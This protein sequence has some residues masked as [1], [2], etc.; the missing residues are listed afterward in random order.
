MRNVMGLFGQ[1]SGLLV[2]LTLA[3]VSTDAAAQ[4]ASEP[5]NQPTV[6]SAHEGTTAAPLVPQLMRYTGTAPNRAGDVVEAT[7][8]VF[9]SQLGGEAL[10]QETQRVQVGS[11]GKFNALLGA[12]TEGGLPQTLF[13]AGQGQWLAVSIERAE[14]QPR[15]KLASVAYAMKAADAETLGGVPAASFVTQSQLAAAAASL[16]AQA[17]RKILPETTPAGSGTANYLAYWTGSAALGDSAIYQGGTATAPLLGIGTATP[18][19]TL[20]V[21]GA[22]IVRGTLIMVPDG[23]ATATA[24]SASP[25][26]A[27]G[28]S[29]FD[30]T[31]N[32]PQTNSFGW[33]VVGLG[34]N[35]PNPYAKLNLMYVAGSAAAKSTGFAIGSTGLVGFAPGQTFPGTVSAI[36]A[37]TGLTANNSGGVV[38]LGI[39]SAQV[40]TLGATFNNFTGVGT[41]S[42]NPGIFG[43]LNATNS[44][45]SSGDGIFASGW[46][47]IGVLGTQTGVNATTTGSNS[48]GVS[49]N[50]TGA[51]STGIKGNGSS[52]GGYFTNSSTNS[53]A[54][55]AQNGSSGPALQ[56]SNSAYGTAAFVTGVGPSAVSHSQLS[57]FNSALW[58]D[59]SA[60]TAIIGSSDGYSGGSFFSNGNGYST[61]TAQNFALN[62][63][64]LT[65][66]APNIGIVGKATGTTPNPTGVLG[67]GVWGVEG[68]GSVRGVYGTANNFGVYG[69]STGGS[70]TVGVYGQ[71]GYGMQAGGTQY[72]IFAQAQTGA[73][74]IAG[75]YGALGGPSKIGAG[76]GYQ[77]GVWADSNANLTGNTDFFESIALLSTIDNGTSGVFYNDSNEDP[78]V[79]A[80]NDG[81]GGGSV[82]LVLRAEGKLG[83]CDMTTAGDTSCTGTLKTVNTASDATK[84]ETYAVQSAENWFEDAGTVQLVNGAAHVSLEP[85]FGKTVNTAIEY[86]V[87]LTPD[88][89]CKGLY[90]SNKTAN[91]F[92]V[93]ELSG[94]QSSIAF[95]YRI[96]AKRAGHEA[97]RLVDVTE[98]ER[99]IQERS[100]RKPQPRGDVNGTKEQ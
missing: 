94:G 61:L 18:E 36:E 3:V 65:A 50:A 66:S 83:A 68:A 64:A 44:N 19:A 11:D 73:N 69:L 63:T 98:R 77:V 89:D 54:V 57:G 42:S 95:E 81:S 40:A 23:V 38:T 92:E 12:A 91:G 10:W 87:F 33:Q 29:S 39:N 45:T 32:A 28:A 78:S 1:V 71:G 21:K 88:G 5:S 4:E 51:S 7:F 93:H 46:T 15:S 76:I 79:F 90:V 84:V 99:E 31:T 37:G 75:V 55:Y 72:G 43:T 60:M 14:E 74:A 97:E 41:F 59:T 56:A 47:G 25:L 35:T 17:S 48:T 26:L 9:A 85:I 2:L 80:H 82:G 20:D 52:Y 6:Q 58:A 100:E 13:A 53:G 67:N 27:V 22:E 86:H 70:Y 16:T 8:R 96:M 34:N 49:A 30:S 62:G 24:A